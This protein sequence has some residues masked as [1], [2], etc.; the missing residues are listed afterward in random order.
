MWWLSALSHQAVWH[1][2]FV[3]DEASAR[4]VDSATA[5][6][7]GLAAFPLLIRSIGSW[8]LRSTLLSRLYQYG[9]AIRLGEKVD[10]QL[11]YADAITTCLYGGSGAYSDLDDPRVPESFCHEAVQRSKKLAAALIREMQ[12]THTSLQRAVSGLTPLAQSMSEVI[13]WVLLVIQKPENSRISGS[14]LHE[15]VSI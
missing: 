1:L 3:V 15:C 14:R 9:A 10:K 7:L 5:A 4:M 13:D 11:V 2:Y 6:R 8:K 12:S